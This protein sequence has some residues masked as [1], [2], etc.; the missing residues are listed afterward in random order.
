MVRPTKPEDNI[1]RHAIPV[2]LTAEELKRVD[3][4]ATRLGLDRS[5]YLRLRIFSDDKRT[6]PK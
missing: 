2:R 1:R 4:V 5:N 3:A 6:A